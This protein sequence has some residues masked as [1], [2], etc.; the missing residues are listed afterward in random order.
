MAKEYNGLDVGES[1]SGIFG[2]DGENRVQADRVN[3]VL[4][5]RISDSEGDVT[6]MET[7]KGVLDYVVS[8]GDKDHP[9]R[10]YTPRRILAAW[11]A[12]TP[13]RRTA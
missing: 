6:A 2:K 12:S 5:I 9:L 1:S 7:S 10:N 11:L 8:T 13:S 4:Q 3:D